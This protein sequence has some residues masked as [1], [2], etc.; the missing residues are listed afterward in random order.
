MA[1]RL[2]PKLFL[3]LNAALLSFSLLLL[4]ASPSWAQGCKQAEIRANIEQFKDEKV[5]Q[6]AQDTVVK[7]DTDAVVPLAEALSHNDTAIRAQAAFA[8]GTMGWKALDAVPDLV[9]ALDDR[10]TLVRRNAVQSLS[11][12]GRAAQKHSHTLSELDLGTIQELD[13]IKQQLEQ[14]LSR[15]EKDKKDWTGKEEVRQELRLTRNALQTNLNYLK[16]RPLY[17]SVQWIRK[18]PW[19][20]LVG[21]VGG[22]LGIFILRPLWLL[23]LDKVLQSQTI[24]LPVVNYQVP[25]DKV[26]IFRYRH[27]VLDAWVKEHLASVQEEFFDENHRTV[28]D[29]KIHIPMPVVLNGKM[30]IPLPDANDDN[31]TGELE[32]K[33]LQQA[34]KDRVIKERQVCLLI[35]GEGGAGKTSLACQ[36]ARW[37]MEGKL[38]NYPMLPVLLEQELSEPETLLDAIRGQLQDLTDAQE[39][40][41]PELLEN[42]LRE[43]RILL[44]VDRLSEMST[45]TREKIRPGQS[46]FPPINILI[47]TS[48]LEEELPG[49][50]KSILKPQRI[51]AERVSEFLGEYLKAKDK[52]SL[53]D[54]EEF[55]NACLR[56]SRMVGQRH[57]TILLARLYADQMIAT[58]ENASLLP[59][60]IPELMLSY[61]NQLNRPVEAAKRRDNLAVHR[62]AEAVAWMCLQQTYRPAPAAQDA[63]L[64]AL[65]EIHPDETKARLDYLKDCL[66][67]VQTV[68]PEDKISIVLD[69]LAEYL[70]GL[71][72]VQQYRDDA[73]KWQKLL[74]E[75]NNKPDA[76]QAIQGFLLALR[77][78]CEVKQNEANIP[79]FVIEELT[80][81]AGLDSEEIQK[82]QQKRRVRMLINELSA[83]EAE[84]RA[85][86]AADLGQMGKAA[87]DAIPRL[88]KV[89]EDESEVAQV[90][91]EAAKAL[92]QLGEE[93]PMLIA[94]IKDGVESI[95]LMKHP[96][97]V[98]IDLGNGVTLEMVRIPGGEFLMG[99]PAEEEKSEDSERPQHLVTVAPFLMG[100]YSVTQAQ[101]Q[102]VAALPRVERE[103]EPNPSD[104]K[105]ELRPVE[106]VSCRDAVEFC[107]RLSQHTGRDFRLPSEA[108]WE[109]ACRAGTTTPFHFGETISTDLANYNGSYTYGSGVAGV[110][111]SQTTPVGMFQ[112]ANAFGLYD[113]HGNVWE[114]CADSW[115]ENYEGA[116]V[117][118]SIWE[119]DTTG[120]NDNDNQK[121]RLLRGGSWDDDP[122]VCRSATRDG[123]NAG[124]RVGFNG[125]RV[126]CSE[127]RTF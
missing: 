18:N 15:L 39:E 5:Q 81:K 66:R 102:A 54:D 47:V 111:R 70:A 60:N 124:I 58:K 91:R 97:M 30:L 4:L 103:L 127:P 75:A 35:Q 8:L 107:K 17:Q 36:I 7:C 6:A 43:K 126:V 69:P 76:A 71:H 120:K 72:L 37:G 24:T 55:L 113:M 44:I 112:V 68:E 104:F 21:A 95:R 106:Q 22:Y 62:D 83:P 116:P 85:R 45:A 79:S 121:R 93:I 48:R 115:H 31:S 52:R 51:E 41:S 80:K 50:M 42:L 16:N 65:A 19:V 57:T 123:Y 122:N 98:E 9:E 2:P 61:L 73:E 13:T 125:V 11:K 86:A 34:I 53:F 118:G 108:E 94:E 26:L 1:K 56:L 32:H 63:V 99:A 20:W 84:Y 29:R 90:R 25:L 67:L 23:Q 92:K 12:I 117:D 109:Y 28:S 119:D 77:D 64:N 14:A 105:G 88:Q 10:D 59:E 82:A 110:N 89:L 74:D 96:S 78:C 3:Y 46:Q 49:V 33:Q 27:R 87:K 101:W 100:K 38:S 114:W 40:I